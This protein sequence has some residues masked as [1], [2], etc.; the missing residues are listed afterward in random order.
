MYPLS[1]LPK[2][3]TPL[4]EP[5]SGQYSPV[6]ESH[7]IAESFNDW[8]GRIYNKFI[9]G[10]GEDGTKI[11]LPGDLFDQPPGEKS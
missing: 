5:F 3:T 9:P 4:T 11:A 8:G 2:R 1:N 6:L 7:M 10:L